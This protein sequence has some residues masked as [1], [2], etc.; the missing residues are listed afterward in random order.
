AKAIPIA[1]SKE[2]PDV[3]NMAFEKIAETLEQG[4]LVCIFPEGKITYDGEISP[5]KPG[6]EKII[7][8]TAVPVIPMALQGLW[9]SYFSRIKGQAMKGLPTFPVPRVKFVAG[10]AVAP[11]VANA[12]FLFDK[13]QKLRGE[14]Q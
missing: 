6:I 8:T 3:M 9:G 4:E 7:N 5:F 10:E 1:P 12:G 11:Q 2:D 13:V 14:T